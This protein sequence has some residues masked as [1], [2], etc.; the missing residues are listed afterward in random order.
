[1]AVAETLVSRARPRRRLRSCLVGVLSGVLITGLGLA[2]V[3]AGVPHGAR[4]LGVVATTELVGESPDQLTGYIVGRAGDLDGDGAEELLV[5]AH[6]D[7]RRGAWAGAAYLLYGPL[8]DGEIQLSDA[9]ATILGMREGDFTAEGWAGVGD[10]DGDGYDDLAISAPGR[11]PAWGQPGPPAPG[12][13]HLFYGGPERIT[14]VVDVAASDVQLIGESDVDFSGWFLAS[15]TDLDADGV[16]DLVIGA[17][18]DDEGGEDAGAVHVLYGGQ[19]W[20]GAVDL[21]AAD[22]KLLGE[23]HGWVGSGLRGIGDLDGDGHDDVAIGTRAFPGEGDGLG[24]VHVVYGGPRWTGPLRL[25]D[26]AATLVAEDADDVLGYLGRSLAGAADLDADGYD[27]LAVGADFEDTAGEDAGAV[28]VI[29]GRRQRLSGTINLGA[30]DAKLIGEA[31]G[32]RAGAWVGIVERFDGDLFADLVVSA[33]LNRRGGPAAGAV[34]V[35]VGRRDR[36]S[37]TVRL[38]DARVALIG[39]PFAFAGAGAGP[40]GDVSGDGRQDLGV[41]GVRADGSE[42]MWV[43]PGVPRL[44]GAC[45]ERPDPR[46]RAGGAGAPR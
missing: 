13:T 11:D 17:A 33:P 5:S 16:H 26:V 19:R 37:G 46:A 1:M 25:D 4:E 2:P 36:W 43:I 3:Q 29:Y 42:A 31:A 6:G 28:Y 45:L 8:P 40:I 32:D 9:D 12:V 27:D 39:T 35:L 15:R 10:V 34:Y 18:R 20:H 23:P 41:G 21:A 24:R 38:A 30:A 14:G 22:A 7:A 44:C